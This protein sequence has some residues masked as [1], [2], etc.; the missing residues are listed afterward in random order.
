MTPYQYCGNNPI[1]FIDSTEM[2]HDEYDKDGNK[3]SGLGGDKIDFHH[4]EDG[5]V[6]ITDRKSGDYT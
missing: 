2:N 4:Q 6:K 5:S 1:M 3:I